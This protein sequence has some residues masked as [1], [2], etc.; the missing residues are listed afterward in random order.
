MIKNLPGKLSVEVV[1]NETA[2]FIF[3]FHSD[4]FGI[5]RIIFKKS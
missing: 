5:L 2:S 3:C 1:R 4:I